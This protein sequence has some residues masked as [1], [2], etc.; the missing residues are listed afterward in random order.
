M[1]MSG[2]LTV[3]NGRSWASV[4]SFSGL[5]NAGRDGGRGVS[6]VVGRVGRCVRGTTPCQSTLGSSHS[7]LQCVPPPSISQAVVNKLEKEIAHLR[8]RLAQLEKSMS[9]P[10]IS[11][12]RVSHKTELASLPSTSDDYSSPP[13][14]RKGRHKKMVHSPPNL[15]MQ[16]TLLKRSRASPPSPSSS[17]RMP[18]SNSYSALAEPIDE[19]DDLAVTASQVHGAVSLTSMNDPPPRRGRCGHGLLSR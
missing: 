19:D 3:A 7:S 11:S 15:L 4:A 12:V 18:S 1:V 6:Q 9:T 16:T 5:S 2:N 14:R 10:T 13:R 8:A 17:T